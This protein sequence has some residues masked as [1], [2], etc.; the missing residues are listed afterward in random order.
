MDTPESDAGRAGELDR[1]LMA[2]F[3][4]C[5]EAAFEKLSDRWWP[6]LMSFFRNQGFGN[7]DA[8]DLTLD[9]LVRL[10]VTKEK[11]AF[12]LSQPLAPFLFT[13]ARRRAIARWRELK[14]EP[15]QRPLE[16]GLNVA[17]EAEPRSDLPADLLECLEQLPE[18]ER[19]YVTLCERHGLG[20]LSHNDIATVLNK[21][22]AQVTQIS[23]RARSALRECLTN[24]GYR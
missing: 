21:W 22:P 2:Q 16:E 20:D 4:A 15:P 9:V 3:Y 23:K 6:R 8:E 1:A 13:I 5:S 10:Y 12:D 18:P 17:A 7:E 14:R 19:T 11:L 24:K